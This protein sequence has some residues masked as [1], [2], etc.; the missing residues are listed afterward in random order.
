MY[1][2]SKSLGCIFFVGLRIVMDMMAVFGF[3]FEVYNKR[4]LKLQIL[5]ASFL[6]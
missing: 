1:W 4:T 6:M 5:Q 2:D 3:S